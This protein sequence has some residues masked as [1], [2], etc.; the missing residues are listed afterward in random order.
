M[1]AGKSGPGHTR[2]PGDRSKI[3]LIVYPNG[4]HAFDVSDLM[5]VKEHRLLGHVLAYD[6]EAT[7]DAIR[8]VRT[9]LQD[10]LKN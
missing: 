9:F 8:Q 1:A 4:P 7:R 10:Q 5:Y 6:D 2:L 3:K